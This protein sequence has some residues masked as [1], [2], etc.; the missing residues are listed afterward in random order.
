M[1]ILVVA[2]AQ[3]E[4]E[5][6]SKA[7]AGKGYG[8]PH[9]ASSV[10]EALDMLEKTPVDVVILDLGALPRGMNLLKEI[11][12]HYWETHR[13]AIA[14]EPTM[15][16]YIES[17]NLGALDC[18]IK[19]ERGLQELFTL[20]ASVGK[21][22][23]SDR[24]RRTLQQDSWR[25]SLARGERCER[26]DRLQGEGDAGEVSSFLETFGGKQDQPADEST[27]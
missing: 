6:L 16:Q 3:A 20:L 9:L 14:S 12:R 21:E 25:R 5:R 26:C 23:A 22:D 11:A 1:E 19:D 10:K 13:I 18:L 2:P 4:R 27:K 15:E 17:V 24:E 7:I 8:N